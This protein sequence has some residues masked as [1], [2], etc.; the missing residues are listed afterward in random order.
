MKDYR[1][2]R[3]LLALHVDGVAANATPLDDGPHASA[4]ERAPSKDVSP[5]GPPLPAQHAGGPPTA[6]GG[7]KE[8]TPVE[9]AQAEAAHVAQSGGEGL[10]ENEAAKENNKRAKGNDAQVADVAVERKDKKRRHER[11]SEEEKSS[12]EHARLELGR[13]EQLLAEER[14]KAGKLVS[15]VNTLVNNVERV[16]TSANKTLDRAARIEGAITDGVQQVV[17]QIAEQKTVAEI[18]RGKIENAVASLRNS[19]GE[20]RVELKTLIE[21]TLGEMKSSFDSS[22][23]GALTQA[24]EQLLGTLGATTLAR[25][26]PHVQESV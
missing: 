15:H 10:H 5:S 14:A 16:T 2:M 12:G 21:K 22:V 8:T 9:T 19:V 25:V 23:A 6:L 26:E 20:T 7:S 3:K 17:Q 4:T 24:A 18:S 13:T 11:R 1:S